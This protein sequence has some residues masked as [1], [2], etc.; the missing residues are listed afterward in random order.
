MNIAI[1]GAGS[2][3]CFL[4]GIATLAGHKV[5]LIG[6]AR[7]RDE[8]IK[9]QGI[10]LSDYE[11]LDQRVMPT[12]IITELAKLTPDSH[13][14]LVLVTLKCHHL[15][16]ACP[17]LQSLANKGAQLIFMQNGL[18]SLKQIQDKLPPEQVLQGITPYNILSKDQAS[19]HR[20][21]EGTLIFEQSARTEHLVD[22]LNA[23]GFP[24]AMRSDMRPVIYGKLLLNLNN[25]L[26]AAS[27]LPIKTQLE[28]SALRKVLA[29][30]MQEWLAVA[31]AEGVQL[32][33]YT[34]IK[35]AMLPTLLALPNFL[36]KRLAKQMLQ[37]DPE[38][39]SSMWEDVELGRQTEIA[40]LNSAVTKRAQE[41]GIKAPVNAQIS[42]QIRQLEAG[43]AR[44]LSALRALA[45]G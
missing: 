18:D 9:H 13:F 41:L 34:V 17:D 40:Y 25:A 38:A 20:G 2:T 37:I 8:I 33:Q 35:P 43:Q 19:F 1:Y 44:S 16:S 7:I 15:E 32:E 27:G 21:T 3:G 11:G 29:K 23:K 14:D 45:R 24:A 26:N 22:S 12:A 42:E 28:D 5:T 4:G 31:K 30:A 39:R 10:H 6:R 36:F